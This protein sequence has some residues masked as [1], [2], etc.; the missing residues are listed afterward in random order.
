MA[1]KQKSPILV[2]FL[3]KASSGQG[4]VKPQP[5]TRNS[6]LASSQPWGQQ[7]HSYWSHHLLPLSMYL[8]KKLKWEV[9]AETQTQTL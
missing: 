3:S 8:S 1:E 9:E 2:A 5:G 4:W 7:G 6:I